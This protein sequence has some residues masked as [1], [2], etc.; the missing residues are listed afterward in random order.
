MEIKILGT[1]C[2][3]CNDLTANTKEAVASIGVDANITKVE[4]IAEII[5]MGVISTPALAVD[6]VVKSTGKLLTVQQIIDILN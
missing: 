2:K 5:K 6:G 3:K 4:D 1:G